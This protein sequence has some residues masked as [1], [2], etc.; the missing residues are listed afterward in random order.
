MSKLLLRLAHALSEDVAD[1]LVRL[2]AIIH[3]SPQRRSWEHLSVGRLD[4]LLLLEE[5]LLLLLLQ[6]PLVQD[7]LEL[8]LHF[9][10]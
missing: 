3:A 1:V 2:D 5:E 4:H 7:L 8:H 10:R 9:L 6:H